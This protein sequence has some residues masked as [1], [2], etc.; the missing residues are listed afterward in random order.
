[1]KILHNIS[2]FADSIRTTDFAR[3]G[4][5]LPT[6]FAN[7]KI[8]EDDTRWPFTAPLIQKYGAVDVVTTEFTSQELSDSEWLVMLATAHHGYPQP[9]DGYEEAT[10]RDSCSE[11]GIP[12]QQFAPF[13]FRKEPT[14]KKT[15]IL[16]LNWVFDEFF[17]APEVWEQLFR[18][19][20]VGKRPA[21]LHKDSAPLKSVVQL[22]I[23]VGLCSQHE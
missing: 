3:V 10:Y 21:V 12:G 5:D 18:P 17:V 19:A 11:C 4:I 14:L 13:R 23:S 22:D 20:G 2:I 8:A 6:D 15:S 7:F 16:Q 1:M 9:E